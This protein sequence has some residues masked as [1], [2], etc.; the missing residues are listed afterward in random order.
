M[1]VA[2]SSLGPNSELNN[3]ILD[4]FNFEDFAYKKINVIRK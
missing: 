1:R 2:Y 3:R 4:K